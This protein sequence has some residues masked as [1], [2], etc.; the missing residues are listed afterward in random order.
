MT[1]AAWQDAAERVFA[2]LALTTPAPATP[3]DAVVGFGHFDLRIPRAC[4]TLFRAGRVRH[5]IFTGGIGAGTADLGAPEADVFSAELRRDFPDISPASV[6][7]ENQSTNTG[8]N[9]RFTAAKLARQQP[10][11]AFGHGIRS[12]LLVA[13]PCR[14]RRVWLTWRANLPDVPA[15][16]APPASSFAAEQALYASK[17]QDIRLQ[18]LGEIERILAYPAKGW[19]QAEPVPPEILAA[20]EQLRLA[21]R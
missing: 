2:Y 6:F 17:G 18:L 20:T 1:A 16:C 5:I 14:Q 9:I 11:L 19:I 3:C 21:P 7:T 13:N 10:A 15:H 8:E 12:A 4:G